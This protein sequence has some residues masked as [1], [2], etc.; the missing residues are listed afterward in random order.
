MRSATKVQDWQS[1]GHPPCAPWSAWYGAR[2]CFGWCLLLL[3][4]LASLF[5]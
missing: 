5:A 3:L 4:T 1:R 2:C